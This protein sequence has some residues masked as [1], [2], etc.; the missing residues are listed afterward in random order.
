M[1]CCVFVSIFFNI[2]IG[3]KVFSINVTK[4]IVLKNIIKIFKNL[5][6]FKTIFISSILNSFSSFSFSISIIKFSLFSFSIFSKSF[7][8]G[9]IKTKVKKVKI[10]YKKI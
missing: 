5:F 1:F 8:K 2:A 4:K 6:D 7:S 3:R 10:K 9:K